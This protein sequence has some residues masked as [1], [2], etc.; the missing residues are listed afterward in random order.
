[1]SIQPPRRDWFQPP[2]GAER[3]WIGLA[4]VWC[5]VMFLMMPYWHFRGKQ[6][7]TGEAYRVEV[8][9]FVDRVDRFVQAYQVGERHG[10]PV[11]EPPPGADAYLLAQNWNWY[12]IIQLR[13][14]QQYRLHISS[15]DLNHGFGLLPMNMNF[16]IVPGYD[17]VLTLTP[18]Q[19][20]EFEIVCNEFCGAGHH[21]MTG[22][23]IVLDE[24]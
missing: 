13:K 20:G 3:M 2:G 15:R 22:R 10:V 9:D 24:E 4:L 11:V 8:Q 19:S 6:N 17:H 14:N 16:H 5:L 12:P 7:S 18:T 1:M 23:I 21:I